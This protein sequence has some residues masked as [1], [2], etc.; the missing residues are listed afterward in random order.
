MVDGRIIQYDTPEKIYNAPQSP[1]ADYFESAPYIEGVV[2]R[3]F[4]CEIGV[5]RR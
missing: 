4:R 2:R 5:P 3:N 1:V